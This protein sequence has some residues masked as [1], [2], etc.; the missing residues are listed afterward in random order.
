MLPNSLSFAISYHR[1][2]I[3][4]TADRGEY[5]AVGFTLSNQREL[6][7]IDNL[8]LDRPVPYDLLRDG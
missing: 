2:A 5:E 3:Q 6:I 8:R 1:Q 4:P 7:P